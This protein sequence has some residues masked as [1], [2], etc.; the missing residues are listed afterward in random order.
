VQEARSAYRQAD[1]A[2]LNS[3]IGENFC[4]Y[5]EARNDVYVRLASTAER[6]RARER[7]EEISAKSSDECDM[8]P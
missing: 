7:L 2:C 1:Q 6:V 5:H 4:D 8:T 3:Y